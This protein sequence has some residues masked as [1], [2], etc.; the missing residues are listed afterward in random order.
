VHE[1]NLFLNS[2]SK[3]LRDKIRADKEFIPTFLSGWDNTPRYKYK[4]TVLRNYQF[5]DFKYAVEQVLMEHPQ[6]DLLFFKSW[7][8]WAEGNVLENV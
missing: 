2:Y 7:N 4:G 8:E 3:H 5:F 6:T 1:A